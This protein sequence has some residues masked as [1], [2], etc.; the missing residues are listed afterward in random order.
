[1]GARPEYELRTA[2]G[3]D[4]ARVAQL[5]STCIDDGFLTSLGGRFLRRL[6]GRLVSSPNGFILVAELKDE[7]AVIGFVAGTVDLR[8]FSVEFA[9]HDGLVA[10]LSAIRSRAGVLRALETLKYS[11]AASDIGGR[12]PGEAELLALA[13]DHPF[14]RCGIGQSLVEEFLRTTGALAATSATVV[15]GARNEGAS[16]LYGRC[17]FETDRR[18]AIHRGADSLVLRHPMTRDRLRLVGAAS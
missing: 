18:I 4:V 5:H 10:A 6:Y 2:T 15:V 16:A 14:R 8:G 1:M 3:A 9:R 17:G 12:R 13:V 11:R 7:G